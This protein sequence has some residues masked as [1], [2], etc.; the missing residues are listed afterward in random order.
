MTRIVPHEPDFDPRHWDEHEAAAQLRAGVEL[1]NAGEYEQA[2][3]AFERLWLATQGA[4][5]DLFKG[6]VQAC[7]ALHH[8]RRGNLEG[9]AKLYGGHRGLLAA[10]LPAHGGLDVAGLLEEMHRVLRPVVRRQPGSEVR[11]DESAR[12]R[13]R[14]TVG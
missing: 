11:F 10:Y 9:A 4:D 6:L 13:M 2:H 14:W 3:E 5:S 8:F 7:I 12:P 1:F